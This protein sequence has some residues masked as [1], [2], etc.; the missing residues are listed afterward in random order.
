[1][2][3]ALAGMSA[4]TSMMNEISEL[5]D[6]DIAEVTQSKYLFES[7]A[8]TL[9]PLQQ[10]LDFWQA[11]RWLSPQKFNQNSKPFPH[12]GLAP[13]LSGRFGD[14]MTV[15]SK[16][17]VISDKPKDNKEVAAINDLLAQTRAIVQ[18][19]RFFHWEVAFPTVWK[20][21]ERSQS[22]GGFDL[23]MSNPPWE[24]LKLQEIEWF[25]VHKPEIAAAPRAADR[26]KL[27]AQLQKNGD[28][29]WNAYMEAKCR[30][31]SISCPYFWR[32]ST[33]FC[34]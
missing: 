24:R 27:I 17:Q 1:M 29:L 8:K 26:K 9:K 2:Q 6:A 23:L 10:L 32:I 25:T 11:L 31:R 3:N 21:L 12:S 4:A 33:T 5:T 19:E 34:G 28:A 15:V 13:L 14:V 7:I 20:H 18:R 16:G 30:N 22:L